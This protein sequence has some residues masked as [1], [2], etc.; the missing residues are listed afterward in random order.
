MVPGP[1][2]ARGPRPQGPGVGLVLLCTFRSSGEAEPSG[3]QAGAGVAQVNVLKD[4]VSGAVEAWLGDLQESSHPETDGPGLAVCADFSVISGE[5]KQSPG[6]EP[7]SRSDPLCGQAARGARVPGEKPAPNSM[8]SG[9]QEKAGKAG[10]REGWEPEQP[11]GRR[12]RWFLGAL[13]ACL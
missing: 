4:G 1:P 11:E 3:R 9:F 8:T 10:Q 2:T 12:A 5:C 7:E 13:G 6:A